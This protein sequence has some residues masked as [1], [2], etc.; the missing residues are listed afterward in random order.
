MFFLRY[1]IT[2]V[3]ENILP[4][5]FVWHIKET[6]R[7]GQST[8]VWGYVWRCFSRWV[9]SY[10]IAV[11]QHSRFRFQR[12]S[13]TKAS[14]VEAPRSEFKSTIFRLKF[15]C[16]STCKR[17]G[18]YLSSHKQYRVVYHVISRRQRCSF[19]RRKNDIIK[20]LMLWLYE[21]R[22]VHLWLVMDKFYDI[23][24]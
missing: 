19:G 3:H 8:G 16:A 11:K 24:L 1:T 7:N 9:S 18:I 21:R 5:P 2:Q 23:K 17:R 22:R 15:H 14:K 4:I 20:S 12:I 13:I 10:V 6:K